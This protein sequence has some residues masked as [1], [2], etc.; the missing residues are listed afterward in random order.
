[1]TEKLNPIER[2]L[3]A[4]AAMPA[5]QSRAILKLICESGMTMDVP[6]PTEGEKHY[7]KREKFIKRMKSSCDRV[8]DYA[9]HE[10]LSNIEKHF[11]ET[12]I[13]AAE[14]KEPTEEERKKSLAERLTF[15]EKL[16]GVAF[17][18]VL[19]EEQQAALQ[20]AGQQLFDEV[21]KVEPFK[22]PL[23]DVQ[24]FLR[25]RANLLANVPDEVHTEIMQ[26]IE[27]GLQHGESRKELM[28]R[29]SSAFDEI[30]RS[31][32]E[33]I[34]NTETA[35][36]FNY[37]R[38][39]AMRE[40]GVTHKRWLHS[41]SPLIKEPRPTH[42]EADGQ[43]VPIDDPFDVGGV[44]FM[45]PADDSLGAGPEDI[46]NC[47]IEETEISAFDVRKS[48]RRWYEGQIV[49]IETLSGKTLTA[50]P[51]HPM[52]TVHGWN[53]AGAL[54]KSDCLV[55]VTRQDGI[56]ESGIEP[57]KQDTPATFYQIHHTLS[58]AFEGKRVSGSAMDFHGDGKAGEVDIVSTNRFLRF[59]SDSTFCEKFSEQFLAFADSVRIALHSDCA[60][61]QHAPTV[62]LSTPQRVSSGSVLSALFGRELPV[63]NELSRRTISA[64]D[65]AF[66]QPSLYDA[67]VNSQVQSDRILGLAAQIS[68]DEVVNVEVDSFRGF[69]HNIETKSG[70]YVA[71]GY[72]ARNCHCVAIPTESP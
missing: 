17:L 40:A 29:I 33:T 54:N 60:P 28:A 53:R 24:V 72:L 43:T 61:M 48:Y 30:G 50:T 2:A 41:M 44:Q 66:G 25:S 56:T 65:S 55:R 59:G 71:Q 49:R 15:E 16:F 13:S 20:T 52:L 36:A 64:F 39:K 42:L 14:E 27:Q 1:M 26:S 67:T 9:K 19:Q 22:L 45:R 70:W 58:I 10:T 38:D 35:A 18:F 6:Q 7:S 5:P 69:V 62:L 68:P 63:A 47:F 34:A 51:N 4:A 32:A 3:V 23:S 12:A 57:N 37:S 21:G 46:I 31:R 8:L 11:R